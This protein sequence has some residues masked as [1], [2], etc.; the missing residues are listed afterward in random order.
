MGPR[1]YIRESIICS[2]AAQCEFWVLMEWGFV[3][4]PQLPRVAGVP[5][6]HESIVPTYKLCYILGVLG[7]GWRDNRTELGANVTCGP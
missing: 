1:S 4:E 2:V 7:A 5:S 6:T 3:W